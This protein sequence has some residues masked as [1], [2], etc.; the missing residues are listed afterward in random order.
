MTSAVSR[1]AVQSIPILDLTLATP[2]DLVAALQS[3][4]CIFLS[5]HGVPAPVYADLLQ[6][7]ADFYALPEA[8]KQAVQWSGQGP[9]RGWQPV[10][11][12]GPNALLLE[13]FE[14]ALEPGGRHLPLERWADTFDQWPA[15]PADLRRAWSQAYII[16]HDLASRLTTMI[17]ARLGLPET[18]L[19]AWTTHQFSNLVVNH[20]LPQVEAP[21]PG[22]VRQR[23]H[24]DIGGLTLLWAEGQ[25]A[26]LEARIGPAGSWVPVAFPPDSILLQA[27][28]LLHLWSRGL[29]PANDHRVVNPPREPGL[30]DVPRYSSVFF[31]QPNL[32]TWVAPAFAGEDVSLRPVTAADHILG[33]QHSSAAEDAGVP[34]PSVAA[35]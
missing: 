10:Y 11:A 13:R 1:P 6:T 17:A 21:E 2:A 23:A 19:P 29:I 34:L 5:N 33:R 8:E 9:W 16:L 25:P 12:G 27:G 4:S 28:D 15:Q 7:A 18:D 3:S 32:A 22:R 20:Y 24:S 14:I 35:G 30:A 31:H 26:G